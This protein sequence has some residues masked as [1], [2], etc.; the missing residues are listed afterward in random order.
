[1]ESQDI[2]ILILISLIVIII[3]KPF[4]ITKKNGN[5]H[6][7]KCGCNKK[8]HQK[9]Q[10][11]QHHEYKEHKEH[12]IPQ[13]KTVTHSDS[14]NLFYTIDSNNVEPTHIDNTHHIE[15]NNTVSHHIESNNTIS[16]N[17]I[18]HKLQDD[19]DLGD[20]APPNYELTK[21]VPRLETFDNFDNYGTVNYNDNN[22]NDDL[23]VEDFNYD[24]T[25]NN[26]EFIENEKLY[27]NF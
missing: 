21:P 5:H 7:H 6:N 1:M 18:S 25:I 23:Y 13:S 15:S 9:H 26:E 19:E 27:M 11:H 3:I 8:H 4:F 16:H 14:D 12:T 2:I 20:Y 17:T 10:Q 24:K 22:N